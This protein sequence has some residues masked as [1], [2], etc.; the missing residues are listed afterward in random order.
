M[1]RV[2]ENGKEEKEIRREILKVWREKEIN[3]RLEVR[4]V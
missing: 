3:V 4:F 2:R 1:K